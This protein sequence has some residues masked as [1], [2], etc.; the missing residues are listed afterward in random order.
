M[1]HLWSTFGLTA[2]FAVGV[3]LFAVLAVLSMRG[4][5][6]LPRQVLLV[7]LGGAMALIL[8]QIKLD[9]FNDEAKRQEFK[10]INPSTVSEVFVESAGQTAVVTN[11]S[12]IRLL[13]SELQAVRAMPAH[14]SHPART[15]DISFRTANQQ[16]YQYRAGQD[17][18]NA[19][20]YWIF[21]LGHDGPE[22]REIGRIRSVQLEPL[23][24]NLLKSKS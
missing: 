21:R 15:F 2:C 13:F 24:G 10:A 11:I 23:L 14:H 7:V 19:D 6:K 18:E 5:V 8:T 17:S 12:D 9:S 16:Q 1:S 3:L 22:G 20:E 4:T